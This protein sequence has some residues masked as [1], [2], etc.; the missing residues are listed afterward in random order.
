MKPKTKKRMTYLAVALA[1][2]V[3]IPVVLLAVG[4]ALAT[5][6]ENLGV[7]SGRLAECPKS[8]NC[9]STQCTDAEHQI[10]P[11]P[12]AGSSAEATRRLK[13]ALTTLPRT[14]IVTETDNYLHAEATSLLFRFV[15]D[16]EFY[17]DSTAKLIHFRSASRTGYSD[18]GV[19]R[20]RME[21]LRAAF[22]AGGS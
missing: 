4:S 10:A 2:V 14:R 13:N 3:L 11:I 20:A 15:D 22:E 8:P 12:F 17:V 21:K 7:H 6:P 16:V 19:N 5:R 18:L 1:I 9:V